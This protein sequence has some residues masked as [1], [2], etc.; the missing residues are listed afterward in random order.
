MNQPGF[1]DDFHGCGPLFAAL[2]L[3]DSWYNLAAPGS[4]T[5][6]AEVPGPDPEQAGGWAFSDRS[7]AEAV[8]DAVADGEF[9]SYQGLCGWPARTPRRAEAE[10]QAFDTY[11]QE[12]AAEPEAGQ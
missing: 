3:G 5:Y 10:Q 6:L 1:P 8:A 11:A 4:T 7:Q 12:L 2:G 9:S